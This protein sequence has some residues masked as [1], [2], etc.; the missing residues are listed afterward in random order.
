MDRK[1]RQ[2]PP[3][4]DRPS[5]SDTARVFRMMGLASIVAIAAAIVACLWLAAGIALSLDAFFRR[6]R[7]TALEAFIFTAVIVALICS[8]IVAD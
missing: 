2:D 4:P 7:N 8:I 3:S 5:S 6:D 1:A